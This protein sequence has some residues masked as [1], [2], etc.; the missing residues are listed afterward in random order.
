M[1][2]RGLADPGDAHDRKYVPIGRILDHLSCMADVMALSIAQ[3][4][5]TGVR[6]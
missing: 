3:S 4:R 6:F 5:R 1:M 2:K